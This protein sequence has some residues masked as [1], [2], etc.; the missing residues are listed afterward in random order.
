M[1]VKLASIPLWC[2]TYR[3]IFFSVRLDFVAILFSALPFALFPLAKG[4]VVVVLAGKLLANAKED[5]LGAKMNGIAV[6]YSGV[7]LL[8]RVYERKGVKR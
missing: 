7:R 8:E 6:C 4:V 2:G 5:L 1:V 3:L